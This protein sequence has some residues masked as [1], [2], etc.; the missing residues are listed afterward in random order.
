MIAAELEKKIC[1]ALVDALGAVGAA[2]RPVIRG[3]WRDASEGRTGPEL[4]PVGTL[5]AVAVGQPAY[6]R[7]MLNKATL[8]VRVTTLFQNA[9]AG[10]AATTVIP[11]AEAI[12]GIVDE[13]QMDAGRLEADLGFKG[14]RP[15]ALRAAGGNAPMETESG[16]SIT[17]DFD[18]TGLTGRGE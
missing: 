11:V 15:F 1:A 17:H 8:A 3:H 13:W 7:F 18:V 10:A 12:C 6:E 4:Q 2:R 14:F 5:V 9:S 16:V